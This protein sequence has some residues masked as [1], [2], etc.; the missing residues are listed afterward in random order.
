MGPLLLRPLTLQC[1]VGTGRRQIRRSVGFMSK[2][3]GV[4]SLTLS[5]CCSVSSKYVEPESRTVEQRKRLE[6][7]QGW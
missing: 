5:R 2:A 4:P 1:L 3:D 7:T 6:M